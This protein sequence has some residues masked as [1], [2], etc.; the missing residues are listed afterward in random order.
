[1][2]GFIAAS[3]FRACLEVELEPMPDCVWS[4][5]GLGIASKTP[6]TKELANTISLSK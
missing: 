1:M 3:W 6:G 4:I 2:P 5:V